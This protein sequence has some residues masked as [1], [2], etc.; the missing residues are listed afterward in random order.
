M[1]SEGSL[2]I[3]GNRGRGKKTGETRRVGSEGGV[4]RA[5]AAKVGEVTLLSGGRPLQCQ[6]GAEYESDWTHCDASQ[7]SLITCGLTGGRAVCTSS[8]SIGGS[9]DKT[10]LIEVR[11]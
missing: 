11:S 3:G 7:R 1:L 5:H 10:L 8:R 9:E 2:L 4:A 6:K